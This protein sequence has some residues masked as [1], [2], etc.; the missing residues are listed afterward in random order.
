VKKSEWCPIKS[1]DHTTQIITVIQ[2]HEQHD[3]IAS[4]HT[5][6]NLHNVGW[7]E[8]HQCTVMTYAVSCSLTTFADSLQ[9][10]SS[11][12]FTDH[13]LKFRPWREQQETT[14]WFPGLWGSFIVGLAGPRGRYGLYLNFLLQVINNN[15]RHRRVFLTSRVLSRF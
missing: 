7:R 15:I 13:K 3:M 4:A 8:C 2:T 10:Q 14:L 1:I 5:C 12:H 6:T 11:H 9:D